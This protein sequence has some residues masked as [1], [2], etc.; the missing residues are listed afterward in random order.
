MAPIKEAKEIAEVQNIVPQAKRLHTSLEDF[1][2]TSQASFLE[3]GEKIKIVKERIKQVEGAKSKILAPINEAKANTIAFF[4]VPLSLLKDIKNRLDKKMANWRNEQLEKERIAK[5]K[6]EIEAQEK[7]RVEKERLRKEAA[8]KEEEARKGREKS[9]ALA[10]K[11]NFE[12]SEKARLE[13]EKKA[14]EVKKL[15]EESKE[16]EVEA[17]EVKPKV[18]KIA[19]LGFRRYWK[20]R[21]IDERIIPRRFLKPDGVAINAYVTENKDTT[22]IPGVEVYF[23]DKTVG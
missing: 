12:K 6:A 18:E 5:R 22:K 4:D 7:E 13:A 16:V 23:E 17:K 11:E 10:K 14:E 20:A 9:E 1:K 21:I 3:A 2:V 8:I 15:K 19:G